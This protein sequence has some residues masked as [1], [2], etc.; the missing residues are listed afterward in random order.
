MQFRTVKDSQVDVQA[1]TSSYHA[2][3]IERIVNVA[4]DEN[5]WSPRTQG[6]YLK[7]VQ[8]A[9]NHARFK[10]KWITEEHDLS[11]LTIPSPDSQGVPYALAEVCALLNVAAE[12]DLRCAVAC[13]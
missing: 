8:A 10:R 9:V 5:D 6:K 7:Y 11:A 13:R 4:A 1:T 12:I 3:D 2:P